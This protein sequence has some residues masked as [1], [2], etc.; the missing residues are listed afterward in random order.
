MTWC[1]GCRDHYDADHYPDGEHGHGAEYGWFG[2][3]LAVED[4]A[5]KLAEPWPTP[6]SDPWWVIYD[7][8][9]KEQCFGCL[10]LPERTP[11][12]V[13]KHAPGCRAMALDAALRADD[14]MTT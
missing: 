14:G 4:A 6:S 5:R 7:S 1:E 13:W 8:D 12:L 10:E 9:D 11:A 3:L 2:A